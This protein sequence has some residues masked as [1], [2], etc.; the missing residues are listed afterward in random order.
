MHAVKDRSVVYKKAYDS[1]ADIPDEEIVKGLMKLA[2]AV[3]A[4]EDEPDA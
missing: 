4:S 1:D 2:A 3:F